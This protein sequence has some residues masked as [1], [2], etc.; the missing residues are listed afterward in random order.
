M[1]TLCYRIRSR[2][3]G[4]QLTQAVGMGIARQRVALSTAAVVYKLHHIDVGIA[5]NAAVNVDFWW[6]DL[7]ATFRPMKLEIPEPDRELLAKWLVKGEGPIDKVL[8]VLEAAEPTLRVRDLAKRVA[9]EAGIEAD[10]ADDLVTVFQNLALTVSR[11]DEEERS[12]V[13][14]IIFHSIVGE[15]A[16]IEQR[17]LF[18]K[19]VRKILGAKS[20]EITAKAMGVLLDHPNTF[21]TARTLS[22]IRPVFR[23]DGMEP[24]AAVIVHQLKIVYHAG[25]ERERGE[26]FIALDGDNLQTMKSVL[27]RALR[28]H[29]RLKALTEKLE[30]PV[31]G[32]VQ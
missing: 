7:R 32:T 4:R 27:D 24:Q 21:C 16:D 3:D 22:E 28:K 10:A 12:S 26:I 6:A 13:P 15:V 5:P 11:F 31:L 14:T 19:R 2:L 9:D 23:E 8:D 20:V 29:E 25:P 17:E 1:F 30:L 18:E